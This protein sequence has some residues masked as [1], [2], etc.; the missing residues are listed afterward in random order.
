MNFPRRELG[1]ALVCG[2]LLM[3]EICLT[4]IFSIV[5]WYH[6]GFLAVSSALLGF[7]SSGVY[8][9]LKDKQII[10]DAS[11][12]P[13]SRAASYAAIVSVVSL[14]LVTQTSFDVYSVVQ[15]R[16]VGTLLAFVLWVTAP[17]FFLGLVI[18]QTLTAHAKRAHI[19][20]GYDLIGSAIGCVLSVG[21]MTLGQSGQA[22]ILMGAAAVASGAMLFAGKRPMHL[23]LAVIA[24]LVT[25]SPLV[26]TDVEEVFPLNSPASK[27]YYNVESIDKLRRQQK[28]QLWK[29][30]T[31]KLKNGS[32]LVIE[33]EDPPKV[34]PNGKVEAFTD[35]GRIEIDLSTVA[36]KAE[37]DGLAFEFNSWSPYRRWSSLSRVDAFHWPQPYGQWGL[38]G[39]SDRYSKDGV[40]IPRQKGI[41]IDAW[42]MT[43]IMR[44]S[45]E[46]LKPV[47]T[48]AVD[49][50]RA[51]LKA[52]EY[53]PAGTVHRVKP[54][55][56]S[57]VC[58]GAGGGLDLLTAKYFGVEKITGVEINPGVYTA[59]REAFP[60]FGGNLYDPIKHPEID[61]HVAEGRSFLERE[62]R[63]FDI[64][65]LSGVDTFSTT[66]AGAFALSENYLYTVE[67]F[68]AFMRR[69][70][71]G[72]VLTLTR[73]FY[74]GYNEERTEI[75]SR[76]ILRLQAVAFESLERRGV[77][78]P[79]QSIFF[80]T[81][82]GTGFTVILIKPEGFAGSE[83]EML[84]THC[85]Y[86]GYEV[87]YSPDKPSPLITADK[88]GYPNPLQAYMDSEDK[89]G[90]LAAE[91]FDQ[92]AP[93]DDRPFFFE[94]S[95]FSHIFKLDH[96]FNELG[97]LTGQG[98]LMVLFLEIFLLGFLFVLV[99]MLKLRKRDTFAGAGRARLGALIYFT[100]IGF[101]FITVEIS[102][103]QK[104]ILF[105]GHPIYALVVILFSVL[106]FSG[107]G[108]LISNR[109][110]LP[111]VAC[112]LAG[113]LALV[114]AFAFQAVFENCLAYDLWLRIAISVALLAPV[115]I[116][117]GLPF[118]IG[119]TVLSRVAPGMIP[120]A[121]GINGY[122]SVLGS[123]LAVILG[124]ELGFMM[125]LF[126]AS[127]VYVMGVVGYLMMNLK[128]PCDEVD[129]EEEL[130]DPEL[131]QNLIELAE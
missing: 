9:S 43:S 40:R 93:S 128:V 51:K 46:P 30:G 117:M 127:G 63:K 126:I 109:F 2:G 111:A 122:T 64:V 103:S 94:V 114:P 3:M 34:L 5:L 62:T 80:L 60:T 69:L 130:I 116:A 66:Q 75:R 16:T 74:P 124:I 32:D 26:F 25:V 78:N 48:A 39:I 38:W 91:Y 101:G 18:S 99:P 119:V 20:Y 106:L 59:M 36:E 67:A 77:E 65:Q 87:L 125:V 102:L 21:I 33:M 35:D 54:A 129:I 31:A 56:K 23:A 84:R 41:T 27:P 8:L 72:G 108:A 81:S 44:Y 105:L 88:P 7:A 92:S 131:D 120:W 24:L 50:E 55:A 28:L 113:G 52:L 83:L 76:A 71:D 14:W 123:V 49:A 110:K 6:F 96:L 85:D 112:L 13:I 68:D 121:W 89:A 98:I 22:T 79:K 100:A 118:P 90:F 37:G 95:R 57:I 1:L 15:D 70:N 58:I 4:K 11:D 86:Y 29:R 73:W 104:F 61:V 47:G 12:R 10:G 45:G 97:G 53:L 42:A 19:F 82:K 17:F 115:G 107:V